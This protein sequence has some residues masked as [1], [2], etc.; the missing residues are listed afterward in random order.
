M[1]LVFIAGCRADAPLPIAIVLPS[2]TPTLTPSAILT[3]TNTPTPYMTP[4]PSPTEFFGRSVQV[5]PGK[6]QVRVMNLTADAAPLDLYLDGNSLATGL[7]PTYVSAQFAILPGTYTA[8]LNADGTGAPVS[9]TTVADQN[10]DLIVAGTDDTRQIMVISQPTEPLRG[11]EVW[12]SFANA[13]TDVG[14]I[15]VTLGDAAAIP[16]D[17]FSASSASISQSGDYTIRAT[18]GERV[19]LEQPITLRELT[20][21]TFIL[22]N[23]PANPDA[24]QLQRLESP[25]LGRYS[26]RVVNL[27][28]ESREVDLY[29]NDLPMGAAI[30]FGGTTT[31][32]EVV[33]GSQRLSVYSAGADRTA[34]APLVDGHIFTGQAGTSLIL[35]LTGSAAA[36]RVI[37]YQDDLAPVPEGSSRLVF[38]NAAENVT[39][40]M[41]GR[42]GENIEEA[43]PI[44]AGQFSAPMLIQ[45]GDIRFTFTDANNPDLGVFEDKLIPLPAGQTLLY[46]VTGRAEVASPVYGYPVEQSA[47][48]TS[49]GTAISESRLR[50]V[51]GLAAGVAVDVYINGILSIPALISP[52]GGPLS[53]ILGED[54]ALLVRQAGD[55]PALLD[56]R[57]AIPTPGDYSVFIFG[58]PVAGLQ[59][60]MINDD[61]LRVTEGAGTLRLVNLSGDPLDVY[62]LGYYLYPPDV[63]PIAPTLTPLPSLTP[64][65]DP[66]F[67]L[68]PAPTP[69]PFTVPMDVRR[70]IRNVG[71]NSAS[72][73]NITPQGAFDLIL[74]DIDNRIL[75]TLH[76]LQIPPGQHYDIV[77]YTHR[78]GGGVKTELFI[79]PYPPR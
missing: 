20:L 75:T 9:V 31:S 15:S 19:L 28:A 45:A 2:E 48:L 42:N 27:S 57:L 67:P 60:T 69:E 23:D 37:S 55:G 3:A 40:L 39:G 4:T 63:T 7:R 1:M 43:R 22:A 78:T 13:L 18:A 79:A 16:L 65:L 73:Q 30:G 49:E 38:F 71:P 52:A 44:R 24:V 72:A 54:F 36:V 33:T 26:V 41:A 25:V 46:A 11:G 76:A 74:I 62:S 17:Q 58:S 34:S 56:L 51:N 64:T 8:S 32:Q 61:G 59:A 14:Q 35:M 66:V 70:L 12:L 6:G 68:T 5:G 77:A 21:Y 10:L 47:A 50:F 29:L 53:P